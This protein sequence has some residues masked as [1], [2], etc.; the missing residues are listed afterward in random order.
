M[1][2]VACSAS[3]KAQGTT[4]WQAAAGIGGTTGK[5][6][7]Q[8]LGFIGEIGYTA[9]ASSRATLD[10]QLSGARLR[11]GSRVCTLLDQQC[12]LRE[13]A[14]V[15]VVGI[16]ATGALFASK[17]TPYIGVSAGAW[18]GR[19]SNSAAEQESTESG[20]MLAAE[21]GYR[22][23]Q[24]ELGLALHQFDGTIRGAVNLLSLVVR[25]RF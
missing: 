25:V 20:V 23:R 14:N 18:I 15:A 10:V 6:L 5:P 13:L 3:L 16:A 17:T 24:F 19:D 7:A 22:V 21:G 1:A 11:T 12:D 2:V 8:G 9:A 4:H